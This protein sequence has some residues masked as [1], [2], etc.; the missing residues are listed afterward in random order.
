[1]DDLLIAYDGASKQTAWW[2]VTAW[3]DR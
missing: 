3:Q 1:M 2:L